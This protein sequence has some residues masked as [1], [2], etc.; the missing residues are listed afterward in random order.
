[1]YYKLYLDSMISCFITVD[2]CVRCCDGCGVNL[3]FR[4][5]CYSLL[6]TNILQAVYSMHVFILKLTIILLN[7]DVFYFVFGFLL[8]EHF[9]FYF[10]ALS[11]NVHFW[12]S[13]FWCWF[14]HHGKWFDFA[15][16]WP[17]PTH[18]LAW[19]AVLIC[20]F[21]FHLPAWVV[22]SE[23]VEVTW[24]CVLFVIG[25]FK[26]FNIHCCLLIGW[27]SFPGS[28][29]APRGGVPFQEKPIQRK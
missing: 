7:I 10:Y 13:C 25:L 2:W 18:P 5:A 27:H 22:R 20:F 1:M 12:P 16:S 24:V 17:N 26:F 11:K 4:S 14:L 19:S 6:S 29:L 28:S 21:R 23:T 8:L 15:W 9:M 3:S